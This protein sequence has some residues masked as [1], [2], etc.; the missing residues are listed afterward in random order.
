MIARPDNIRRGGYEKSMKAFASRS[1]L[2][3]SRTA[4]FAVRQTRRYQLGADCRRAFE[5]GRVL[6]DARRDVGG[7]VVVRERRVGEVREAVRAH[8]GGGL[9]VV[10]PIGGGDR[11]GRPVAAV[12]E[13]VA[14]RTVSRRG[15]T[16]K[17]ALPCVYDLELRR[18]SG[19]VGV[20]GCRN[21]WE[22]AAS[23]GEAPTSAPAPFCAVDVPAV[24]EE[25]TLATPAEPAPPQPAAS[26]EN[27]A[28]ATTEATM[29]GWWQRTMFGS[30]QS[31]TREAHHCNLNVSALRLRGC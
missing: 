11:L 29:S 2:V 21:P 18:V 9:E 17:G 23:E 27:A 4:G 16:A 22:R 28:T 10:G 26:S 15:R 31:R 3:R 24:V 19:A 12:R 8:A 20:E 6:V 30:F 25:A 13:Q 1:R 14:A 5:L 7:D